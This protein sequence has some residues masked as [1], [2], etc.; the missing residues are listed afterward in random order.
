MSTIEEIKGIHKQELSNQKVDSNNE[1]LTIRS[2][3]K[4]FKSNNKKTIKK[5][6]IKIS[7]IFKIDDNNPNKKKMF[8]FLNYII[9]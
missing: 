9:I 6:N 7:T 5:D 4:T 8:Q 2:E 3:K 1:I